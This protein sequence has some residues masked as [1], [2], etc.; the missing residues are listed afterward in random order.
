MPGLWVV[1]SLVSYRHRNED[2]GVPRLEEDL[3]AY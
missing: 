1:G 3:E 2:G